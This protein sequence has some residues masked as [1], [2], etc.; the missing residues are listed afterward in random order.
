M[1]QRITVLSLLAALAVVACVT[2]TAIAQEDTIP[3][4]PMFERLR[5]TLH[6]DTGNAP[7]TPLTTWNGSFVYKSH[8]YNYNMVGTDPSTGTSTTVKVFVIPDRKS[9]RLNSSHLGISY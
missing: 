1:K 4:H 7:V 5:P 3:A 9:T 2:G 8:T 6:A